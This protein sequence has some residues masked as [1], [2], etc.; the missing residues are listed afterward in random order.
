MTTGGNC[1]SR[2]NVSGISNG[3]M[4]GNSSDVPHGNV[5][6]GHSGSLGRNETGSR[7]PPCG[8]FTGVKGGAHP[9]VTHH[10]HGNFSIGRNGTGRLIHT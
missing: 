4:S 1:P 9:N 8:N 6:T 10:A 7:F 5:T 2:F 3:P